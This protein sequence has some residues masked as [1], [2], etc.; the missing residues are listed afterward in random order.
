MKSKILKRLRFGWVLWLLLFLPLL[1]AAVASCG[2]FALEFFDPTCTVDIFQLAGIER[3]AGVTDVDL[4]FF[5]RAASGKCI[6]TTA[7]HVGFM[8]FRMDFFLHGLIPIPREG[9]N[10]KQKG[11]L[12]YRRKVVTRQVTCGIVNHASGRHAL[13]REQGEPPQMAVGHC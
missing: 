2:E 3:M 13:G 4:Q 1:K 7:S 9:P 12:Q 10:F 8:I 6:T 11:S 5:P